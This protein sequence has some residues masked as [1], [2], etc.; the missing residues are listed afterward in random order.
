MS[1]SA[2]A[3][4]LSRR[5]LDQRRDLQQLEV[6]DD[7]VGDVEVGVQAQLAEP[8]RRSARSPGPAPRAAPARS[9]PAAPRSARSARRAIERSWCSEATA[10]RWRTR[11]IVSAPGFSARKSARQLLQAVAGPRCERAASTGVISLRRSRPRRS[12]SAARNSAGCEA[13][14]LGLDDPVQRGE[15]LDPLARLGGDLGGFDRRR[16]HRPRGRACAGG[17]P[18]SRG[19]GRPGAAPPAGA[20]ARARPGAGVLGSTSSRSQA[21]TSR[22]CGRPEKAVRVHPPR[23]AVLRARAPAAPSRSPTQTLP[24]RIRPR[25][26]GPCKSSRAGS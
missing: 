16:P 17:R 14:Q 7:P 1:A 23:A 15:A 26:A 6:A 3:E 18:G 5:A 2:S 11:S 19:R 25:G 21:I 9:A 22:T 12:I 10:A 13:V 24:H 8:V 4:V 20:R